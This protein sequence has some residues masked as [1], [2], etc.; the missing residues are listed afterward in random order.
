MSES[1]ID[2]S[3][4]SALLCDDGWHCDPDCPFLFDRDGQKID[5][6]CTKLGI[7]LDWYDYYIAA[8]TENG[9]A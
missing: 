5:G 1:K 6:E 9:S 7:T 3:D 4:L 2:E 8:C